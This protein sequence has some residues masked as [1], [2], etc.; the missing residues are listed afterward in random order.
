MTIGS[1]CPTAS[2]IDLKQSIKGIFMLPIL[3]A[4]DDSFSDFYLLEKSILGITRNL[5]EDYYLLHLHHTRFN[6]I[7]NLFCR[8]HEVTS[9][10]IVPNLLKYGNEAKDVAL[11]ETIKRADHLIMFR[12]EQWKDEPLSPVQFQN[13]KH[14][15]IVWYADLPLLSQKV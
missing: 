13:I 3:I 6:R 4:A 8:K 14:T 15:R 2:A 11:Q 5:P 10:R 9:E 1:C 7:V 12:D